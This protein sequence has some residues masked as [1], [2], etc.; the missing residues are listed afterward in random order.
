MEVD[1]NF[2]VLIYSRCGVAGGGEA[3]EFP[4]NAPDKRNEAGREL[5]FP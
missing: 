5:G 2:I 1:Q 3:G 4:R